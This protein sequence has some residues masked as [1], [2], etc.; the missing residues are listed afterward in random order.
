MDN[1][2]MILLVVLS[3]G[4]LFLINYVAWKKGSTSLANDKNISNLSLPNIKHLSAL[5]LMGLILWYGRDFWIYLVKPPSS[6]SKI[7]LM[8]WAMLLLATAL[9][10]YQ[11]AVGKNKARASQ[12][13]D[14]TQLT[15]EAATA[16]LIVRV[17]YLVVYECYFRGL[18]LCLSAKLAGVCWALLINLSAYA[19]LH[20]FHKR[21]EMMA[22]IPFGFALC[23][24]TFSS[25]S[26]LP[27][28][29]LHLVLAIVNESFLLSK[30]FISPKIIKP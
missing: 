16:Y 10:A 30:Y 26:L 8:I 25:Q 1:Y 5:I 28:I 23:C 4:A 14:R 6:Y 13:S 2:T 7:W 11:Q 12:D 3:Y 22:C 24:L 27:A 29:L 20:S 19:V 9:I 15:P 21:S 18:L 17:C